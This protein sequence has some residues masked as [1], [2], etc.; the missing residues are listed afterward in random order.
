MYGSIDSCRRKT[1]PSHERPTSNKGFVSQLAGR[2]L[3]AY[4]R[5]NI[6]P[7]AHCMFSGK[8]SVDQAARVASPFAHQVT[9]VSQFSQDVCQL[10]RIVSNSCA[11]PML[12]EYPTTN[13]PAS[14]HA[15]R[16][17]FCSEGAGTIVSSSTQL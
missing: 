16:S 12:P 5:Q 1:L 9:V 14:P 2:L 15:P 17:R 13:L 10:S 3:R 4:R 11:R 7:E 6:A 8:S